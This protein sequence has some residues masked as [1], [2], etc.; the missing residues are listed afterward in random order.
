MMRKSF[1]DEEVKVWNFLVK[2]NG[3]PYKMWF[4]LQNQVIDAYRGLQE[5][6]LVAL[7]FKDMSD[8][9]G[10]DFLGK[11]LRELTEEEKSEI[12]LR[13]L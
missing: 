1:T 5:R 8:G 9:V 11:I 13:S 3:R 7:E 4:A 12:A 2:R 6:G 10:I